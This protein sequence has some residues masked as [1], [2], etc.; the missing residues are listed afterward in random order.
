MSRER[1][2]VVSEE[3]VAIRW[4][5]KRKASIVLDLLKGK[6]TMVEVCREYDLKQS[7][8][9][10]WIDL[11]IQGGQNRLRSRP[12]DE[13]VLIDEREKQLK[14]KIGELVMEVDVLKKALSPY[15]SDEET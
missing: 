1:R 13:K 2:L 5:A 11:F 10:E 6:R 12:R 4:T 7:E 14:A 3:D 9:E 8:V 15:P